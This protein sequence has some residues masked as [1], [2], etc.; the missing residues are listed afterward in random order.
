[1]TAGRCALCDV[2]SSGAQGTAAKA[3]LNLLAAR[4][5]CGRIMCALLRAA[6]KQWVLEQGET[7]R[8]DVQACRQ[9]TA[10][11]GPLCPSCLQ[12]ALEGIKSFDRLRL[13]L[14]TACAGIPAFTCENHSVRAGCLR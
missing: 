1:M 14:P 3:V 5:G 4:S 7:L 9:C 11:C 12:S 6:Y 10:T 8:R 2:L 13:R